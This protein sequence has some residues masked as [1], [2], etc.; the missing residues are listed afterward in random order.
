M[1]TPNVSAM[2]NEF[3]GVDCRHM[4]G[5]TVRTAF[6]DGR[7]K[8]FVFDAR[9]FLEYDIVLSYAVPELVI[10][11]ALERVLRTAL[12]VR[13]VQLIDLRLSIDDTRAEVFG[14]WKQKEGIA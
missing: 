4:M 3:G 6:E 14:I 11:E 8:I 10:R 9:M 2:R 5:K 1:S 7:H 13:A 12:G